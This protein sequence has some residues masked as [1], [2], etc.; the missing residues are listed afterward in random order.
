MELKTYET[1]YET[2]EFSVAQTMVVALMG[3]GI[4]KEWPTSI[5]E[6]IREPLVSSLEKV[7]EL[8]GRYF[9]KKIS[10]DEMHAEFDSR[11][12]AGPRAGRNTAAKR[13][14]SANRI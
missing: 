2:F 7:S 4:L 11:S 1:I 3:K 9:D 5:P 8:W 12:N 13:S 10:S 14:W 6:D